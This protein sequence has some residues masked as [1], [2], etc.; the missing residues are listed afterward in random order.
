MREVENLLGVRA[1]VGDDLALMIDPACELRTFADALR[2]GRACDE[3]DYFWYEDPYRDATR[4]GV[5]P[6]ATAGEARVRRSW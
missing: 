3:A 1:R 5:R 6:Q 2:V 4:L